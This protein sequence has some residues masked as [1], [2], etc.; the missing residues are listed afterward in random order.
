MKAQ[1]AA[2]QS[3]RLEG[4]FAS[5]KKRRDAVEKECKDKL[6]CPVSGLGELISEFKEIV[7]TEAA[8]AEIVLGIREG[9]LKVPSDDSVCAD[10]QDDE[11]EGD[12]DP[13]GLLG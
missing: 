7:E 9:I 5:A 11:D 10:R 2:A 12:D 4:E 3:S 13:D 6:D 1:D 8:N